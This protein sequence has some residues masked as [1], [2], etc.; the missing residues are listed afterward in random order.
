[1]SEIVTFPSNLLDFDRFFPDEDSCVKY[2]QRERWP[3]G[4]VCPDCGQR[5]WR[6]RSRPLFECREGH[7]TSVT[8][9]TVF[10]GSRKPLRLWFRVI[11][12]MTAQKHGISAT[13]LQRLLGFSSYQTAWHWLHKLRAAMV[14]KN[15]PKLDAGRV[16]EDECW[17]P[18]ASEGT[19][20]GCGLPLIVAAVESVDKVIGRVRISLIPD[21]TTA[22]LVKF[23]E[24]NVAPGSTIATDG[25]QAYMELANRGFRHVRKVNSPKTLP[26]I[27]RVF[28]LLQRWILGTHQGGV[29]TDH[30]QAY[31]DEFTFRFNR[32]SSSSRGKL[33]KRLIEQTA[34]TGPLKWRDLVGEPE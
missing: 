31:L 16:E 14:R 7:Q 18:G 25:W 9:G 23:T 19:G 24:E 20:R 22:T 34:V 1:M 17:M 4:F 27:H 28:G 15:R 21:A 8:A 3:A 12:L 2:L 11:F 30:Y 6:L 13:N 33:F 32:R 29:R 5:G 26:A 10:H